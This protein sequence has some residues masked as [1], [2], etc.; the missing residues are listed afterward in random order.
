[1]ARSRGRPRKRRRDEAENTIPGPETKNRA[2]ETK[3]LAL[4]GRYVLKEF[5]G[6]G[7]FLGK[8]VH[9]D[10]GLYRVNYEDGDCEDL[11]SR[12][13]RGF[14]LGD[15]D[16]DDDLGRRKKKLEELI[17]KI[18]A[19]NKRE[20]DKKILESTNAG[21]KVETSILSEVSGG[22]TTEDDGEEVEGDADSSTDSCEYVRDG[23]MDLGFDLETPPIP[24]PELPPSSGTI[25]VPEQYVSYLFSVYGFLRSFSIPLFLSPFTLDDFVGSLNCCVANTLL[26]AVHVVLMRTLRR[27]LETLSSDG[28][29]LASKCLRYVYCFFFFSLFLLL[30]FFQ[31]SK[32]L[33]YLF[34]YLVFGPH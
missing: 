29:E 14:V 25:G 5:D 1:M 17:S 12:E 15:N 8:V 3:P 24:P 27:H 13:I 20:S 32:C 9:Y 28:F 16:F 31:L 6:S 11:E 23:D 33:K 34:P 22:L 4:V 18:S 7:I 10:Q 26:D 19:N 21:D 2:V 30:S